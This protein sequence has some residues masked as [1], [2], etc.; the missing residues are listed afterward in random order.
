MTWIS[1]L[2]QVLSKLSLF[3]LNGNLECFNW[4]RQNQ[5]SFLHY[6]RP[7][8]WLQV[9]FWTHFKI[10]LYVFKCLN[11]RA[12][13]YLFDRLRPCLPRLSQLKHRGDGSCSVTRPK[14]W[15]DEAVSLWF[16][17][18]FKNTL[19]FPGSQPGSVTITIFWMINCLRIC[20]DEQ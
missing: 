14:L 7:P 2:T 5:S 6:E 9:H 1:R 12:P 11:S 15:S 8:L 3:C 10:L 17:I 4:S 16:W 13:S 18:S 19:V 20:C